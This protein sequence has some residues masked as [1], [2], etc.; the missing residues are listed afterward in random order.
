[1]RNKPQLT[2]VSSGKILE[3]SQKLNPTEVLKLKAFL[4]V[5]CDLSTKQSIDKQRFEINYGNWEYT[6]LIMD[7]GSVLLDSY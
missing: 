3:L 5:G 2:R 4:R 7:K 1:M 6:L